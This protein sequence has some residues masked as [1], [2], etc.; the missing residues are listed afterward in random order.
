MEADGGDY[1]P[2]VESFFLFLGGLVFSCYFPLGERLD[3]SG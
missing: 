3:K 2:A 1:F